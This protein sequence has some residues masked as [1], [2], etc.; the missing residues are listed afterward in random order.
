MIG[1]P[2]RLMLIDEDPV[3]R[4][5]L[6]IWLEQSAGYQVVAEANQGQ[7]ALAILAARATLAESH[8]WSEL[9]E[10]RQPSQDPS[11]PDIDLVIL[12]LGLGS[13]QP[14]QLPGLRLCGEIKSRYPTLPVLILSAEAEPVLEAAARQMGADGFGPRG[15]PVADL[16]SLIAHLGRRPAQG[17]A[18]PPR[19][20]P[21]RPSLPAAGTAAEVLETPYPTGNDAS[22]YPLG[23]WAALRT[24]L[25]QSSVA[26]IEA[27]MAAIE[28]ERRRGRSDLWTEAVLAGRYRELKA[29]RWLVGKLLATPGQEAGTPSYPGSGAGSRRQTSPRPAAP[30]T[31]PTQPAPSP[32]ALATRP[33]RTPGP[34]ASRA[35]ALAVMEAEVATQIFE[36]VFG[37]LQGSLD[38]TSDI[39]LETDI[40]RD[41]RKR[42]LFY[43]TLRKF[44]DSLDQLRQARVL[45]GQLPE[46]APLVLRDVWEAT[47]TDFF[48]RY[49]TLQVGN[50]EQPVVPTLMAEAE[51]VKQSILDRI[52]LVPMLLGH[53]L[54]QD[55]MV[56]D[57]GLYP[58]TTP[59]ALERSQALL[60]HLLIQ[61][62]NGVIQPLLNHFADVE[63]I[64]KNLYH[65]R[66][67]TSRDIERFRNDL[68]WRYRWDGWIN[69][70]KAV[71]ESQYRLLR[72][73]ERGIQT[74]RIYAPRRQ[75][76]DQLSGLQRVV[77][78]TIEARDA[79]APRFRAAVSLVGSGIVYILTDVIG[80]GIGLIG[81]GIL[82]GVGGAWRDPRDR[83]SRN[84]GDRSYEA[85]E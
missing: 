50:L 29:A 46:K 43:L 31:R 61:I 74:Q 14:Q 35:E 13:N 28:A 39:P 23:A 54:F 65:R 83:N 30:P 62:A 47:L 49:Y 73:T 5:G 24:R 45:P 85:R 70:P 22:V 76:L 36:A 77:T 11:Q 79:V 34:V 56:V 48:G 66:V 64:K 7:D 20:S 72:L 67:M 15:M 10:T 57:G 8:P 51:V 63:L 2:L 60:E 58:A 84:P 38:N 17:L 41:D 75:E 68:S 40:L 1:S 78:L 69:E 82:R 80:R 16:A 55:G 44:E 32:R 25:R 37:K 52:P 12:D 53:L 33:Q 27:V 18:Q 3:F 81:R 71:F 6:R 26:Q 21:L 9:D 19:T 4:L 42:E 59:E